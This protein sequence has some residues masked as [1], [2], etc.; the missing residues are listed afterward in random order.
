MAEQEK[1]IEEHAGYEHFGLS[2]EADSEAYAGHANK[3]REL[4]RKS[5][6]SAIRDDSKEN[7]AIWEEN[8][9]VREAAFGNAAEAKK[10]AADG[11]KLYPTS[12]GVE[13]EAALA[14]AMAGDAAHAE[15][16]A[17][18]L[19]QRFPLDTQVQALWLPVIRAQEAL[20]RNNTAAAIEDLQPASGPI[21]FGQTPFVANLS[22]LYPTYIRGAAYLAAGQGKTA[23]R[24]FQKILEHSGLVWN[25]WTGALAKL[26]VARAHALE[27]KTEQGADADA[28]RV[29]ALAGYK[30]FLASW[31]DADAD[32]PVLKQ[33]RSEYA[34]LQ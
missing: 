34:K 8:A 26:G 17:Q 10:A 6:D 22:C 7:G 4:T 12:Q 32:V 28:A 24:E 27:A 33:A 29:R 3:A 23:A 18:D 2:M 1:W 9:A 25:C 13:V 5:V 11:L 16:M 15:S 19:N 21:E 20:D 31:K 14:Y 30:D